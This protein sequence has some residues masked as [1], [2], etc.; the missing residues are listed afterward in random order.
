MVDFYKFC[1]P[2]RLK[3]FF[4]NK[5]RGHEK[6]DPIP[7]KLKKKSKFDPQINNSTLDIF[8]NNGTI[9]VLQLETI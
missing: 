6:T 9:Q 3:M 7:T 8:L 4:S 1:R 2:L 5:I